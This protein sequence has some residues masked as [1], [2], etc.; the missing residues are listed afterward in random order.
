[1]ELLH[2]LAKDGI[3]VTF[4]LRQ[5]LVTLI[6]K[7]LSWPDIQ[8]KHTQGI[9]LPISAHF[10]NAS[11]FQK[12]PPCREVFPDCLHSFREG[13]IAENGLAVDFPPET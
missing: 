11:G 10:T 3:A 5:K 4:P 9:K 1:M 12:S 6:E 7:G 8:R 2:V 13:W